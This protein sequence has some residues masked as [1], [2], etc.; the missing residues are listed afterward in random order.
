MATSDPRLGAWLTF[1]ARDSAV[2]CDSA[3]LSDRRAPSEL[4]VFRK[5]PTGVALDWLDLD[6]MG[7]V[8]DYEPSSTIS[9]Q[10]ARSVFEQELRRVFV[11]GRT[12][13]LVLLRPEGFLPVE[14]SVVLEFGLTPLPGIKSCV[15]TFSD[16]Q[17]LL[18]ELSLSAP[19][20]MSIPLRVTPGRNVYTLQVQKG[21]AD[22]NQD[23]LLLQ[24][25]SIERQASASNP[26]NMSK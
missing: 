23:L 7:P 6:R 24:A 13:E 1:F 16:Q 12:T 14:K 17:G 5:I 18:S 19:T 11:L 26:G 21:D 4:A 15:V 9:V 22:E 20:S 8:S 2:Y 10:G 3:V 25:L